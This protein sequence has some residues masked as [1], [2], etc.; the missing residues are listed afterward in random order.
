MKVSFKPLSNSDFTILL[1]WLEAP[2]VKKWVDQ[3]VTYTIDLVKEKYGPY[4]RGYKQVA[5]EQKPIHAFIIYY[6]EEPIGY[7]QYYN[8]YDFPRDGYELQN[9][10]T[11]LAAVDM[12]IGD[13]LYLGKGIG[14]KALALFLEGQIYRKF[15]YAFV[16]PAVSN[17]R[18]IRCYEKVGFSKISAIKGANVILM[19]C[20]LKA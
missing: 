15:D 3:D 18:A 17:K 11:S 9:L 6:D 7:I 13:E 4:V 19:L 1:S 16:D 8:A 5:D 2:H 20:D 12:F 10:P 14:E